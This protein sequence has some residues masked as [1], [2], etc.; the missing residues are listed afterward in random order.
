MENVKMPTET[1]VLCAIKGKVLTTL[2]KNTWIGDSSTLCCITNDDTGIFDVTII[3]KSV[4]GS[5]GSIPATN[6][7]KLCVHIHQVDSIKQV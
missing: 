1:G 4:E 3:N 2:M 5:L 6:K 7:G